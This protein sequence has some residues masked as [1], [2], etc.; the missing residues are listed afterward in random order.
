MYANRCGA[1]EGGTSESFGGRS[2]I[3]TPMGEVAMQMGAQPGVSGVV[4]IDTDVVEAA[5]E[6]H[7]FHRDLR[8]DLFARETD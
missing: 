1:N 4:V 6:R 8:R 7:P 2:T 3:V 5:R